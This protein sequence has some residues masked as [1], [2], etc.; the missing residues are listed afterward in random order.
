MIKPFGSQIL[1]KPVEQKTLIL[2]EKKTLCE[3]GEVLAVGKEVK[4]IKVGDRIGYV[5]WGLNF[6]DIDGVK[7]YFVRE[8][9]D[10]ILGIIDES[11]EK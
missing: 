10:Y 5:L 9:E 2:S 3:Y 6:L 4:E 1:V 7:H 11:V 8:D